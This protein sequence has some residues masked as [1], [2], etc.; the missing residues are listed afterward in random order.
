MSI[1]E[2]AYK[3]ARLLAIQV[4]E[5]MEVFTDTKGR[6]TRP[7]DTDC[8]PMSSAEQSRLRDERL[9][10]DH[11]SASTDLTVA[12]A[13]EAALAAA[14]RRLGVLADHRRE[15]ADD[16]PRDL[17]AA[18]G[19]TT[20]TGRLSVAGRLLFCDPGT[21]GDLAVV[22]QYK[23]TP[24]GE[25]RSIHRLGP[26]FLPL[27]DDLLGL[28]RARQDITSINLPDGQQVQIEQF[29]ELA[30]REAIVNALIHQDLRA[31]GIVHIE[32]SPDLFRVLS[33]GPLVPGVTPENI[34]N[35]ASKP[36]NPTLAKA[37][38]T[39]GLA[40]EIGRGVDRMY[41]EMIR[42]GK[43]APR[44]SEQPDSVEVS[45]I[46]GTP[47]AQLA[48]YIASLPQQEQ[49]DTDT[50]LTLLSLCSQE[51]VSAEDLAPVLQRSIEQTEA[52]LA[53]LSS[54]PPELIEATRKTAGRTHPEYQLREH[55]VKRLGAALPY[56]TRTTDEIDRRIIN[57][58]REWDKITNQTVQNL[59]TV[60]VY[61]A[62]R[63]L[64]DLRDRG[65]IRKLPGPKRGP[66]VSWGPGPKFPG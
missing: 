50:L 2:V 35:H 23:A 8:V 20:E 66:G 7:L 28:I 65:V 44:I 36:R 61:K 17:L 4:L 11:S 29:P 56:R 59:L 57:H 60:D 22:Y 62:S 15:L 45:L 40:E 37:I 14:R 52:V 54:R 19:V 31:E 18:L 53:R 13:S 10:V 12:D 49:E 32:H 47:N 25:P 64:G 58:L 42:S 27:L 39:I 48:R 63:I 41:R 1:E 6:A 9:G 30:V 26:P 55:V 38:R 3:G 16:D 46:G 21:G 43:D 51:T 5:G 33:P 34:L 24:G